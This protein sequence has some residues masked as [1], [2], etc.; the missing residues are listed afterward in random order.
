MSARH[1]SHSAARRASCLRGYV[2]WGGAVGGGRSS[3][4]CSSED[5]CDVAGFTLA[6]AGGGEVMTKGGGERGEVMEEGVDVRGMPGPCN[7]QRKNDCSGAPIEDH[8]VGSRDA[9]STF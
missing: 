3:A 5:V 9:S 7:W 8:V 6:A 1:S 4:V 2:G